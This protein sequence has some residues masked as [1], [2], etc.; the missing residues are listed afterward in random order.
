MSEPITPKADQHAVEGEFIEAD[1]QEKAELNAEEKASKPTQADRPA[2]SKAARQSFLLT[3][4]IM[5]VS[6]GALAT[7]LATWLQLQP[8]VQTQIAESSELKHESQPY[9]MLDRVIEKINYQQ[10]QIQQTRQELQAQQGQAQQIEQQFAAIEAQLSEMQHRIVALGEDV[11]QAA[12]VESAV[13]GLA[14]NEVI[15]ENEASSVIHIQDPQLRQDLNQLRA[16]LESAL[17]QVNRELE[18]LNQQSRQGL[19]QLNDY[20]NS[21]QW[22]QDKAKVQAQVEGISEQLSELASQQQQWIERIK[23]QIEQ[24]LEEVTPQLEGFLSIF[25]QLFSIKKHNEAE[26]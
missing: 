7:A 15:Q 2:K 1:K 16:Q 26:E 21:E 22:Q 14:N 12:G 23:P 10:N 19:E 4:V 24:T 6:G 11:E 3:L 13:K 17:D 20:V 8:L 9:P 25:N 5:L 18:Q